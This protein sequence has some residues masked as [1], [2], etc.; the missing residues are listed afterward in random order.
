MRMYRGE[1]EVKHPKFPKGSFA[2]C[3]PA[4][5]PVGINAPNIVYSKADD[6]ALDLYHR[7]NV[8]T[9]WHSVSLC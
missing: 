1:Y 2:K 3:G 9:S 7:E 8:L 6:E 4:D 5:K